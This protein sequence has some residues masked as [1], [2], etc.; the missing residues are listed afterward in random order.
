MIFDEGVLTMRHGSK[1]SASFKAGMYLL[2]T[3]T[4]GMYNEPLSIY[5]EYIQNSVDSIDLK[6]AKGKSKHKIEI[7]LDPFNKRITISDNG[8]GLPSEIAESILSNIGSSEKKNTGLRGFRGI[9]RL[10]GLAFS[11]NATFH[12]KAA[13]EKVESIQEWDCEKLRQYMSDPDTP[14]MSLKQLFRRIT[15]FSQQNNKPKYGSYFKVILDGV[16]SFRNYVFDIDKVRNYLSEVAP[17]PFNTDSFSYGDEI[18]NYLQAKLRS[19]S[20]YE[21]ILNGDKLFKRYRD[22]IRPT[23]KGFDYIDNVKLLELVVDDESIAYGWYGE[24]RDLLGAISKGDVPSGLRVRVGNILLGDA[25]LLDG[26]F[27]EARFNSYL[28]GEIHVDHPELIPNSR[29]DGFVDNELKTRLY[30]AIEQEIGLPLSKE[31]RYRS[32]TKSKQGN[33]CKNSSAIVHVNQPKLVPEELHSPEMI[34]E[35]EHKAIDIVKEINQNCKGCPRLSKILSL[36]SEK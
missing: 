2:E 25:H 30:D 34:K 7:E 21:V 17:L 5:R 28:I 31:I 16:S 19:Y 10:G 23:K 36:I 13:E 27:R 11:K 32:R 24:R 3:L 18:D 6:N 14:Q 4:S 26:C 20:N 22:N 8:I 29:R 33:L 15:N 9:G 12:T 35:E 1:K